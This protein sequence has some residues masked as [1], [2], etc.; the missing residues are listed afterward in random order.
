MPNIAVKAAIVRAPQPPTDPSAIPPP[1][2]IRVLPTTPLRTLYLKLLKL[3]R[4]PRNKGDNSD[5][6]AELWLKMA[7]GSFSRIAR[8]LDGVEMSREIGWWLEEMSEVLLCI[9]KQ[10]Q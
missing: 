8:D 6:H 7:D 5:T 9:R 3:A 4:I 1:T 2:I 10:Q